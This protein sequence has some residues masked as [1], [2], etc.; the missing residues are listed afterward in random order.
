VDAVGL[1]LVAGG[2]ILLAFVLVGLV[3]VRRNAAL[4]RRRKPEISDRPAGEAR[5]GPSQDSSDGPD[6]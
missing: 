3:A 6:T 4:G 5:R 1:W 2:V